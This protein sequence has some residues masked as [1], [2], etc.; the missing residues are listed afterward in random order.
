MER[1]GQYRRRQYRELR[2][3]RGGAVAVAV[4]ILS[5]VL[6]LGDGGGVAEKAA[7][8]GTDQ[9]GRARLGRGGDLRRALVAGSEYHG[10]RAG[11]G[12]AGSRART[13]RA[14]RGHHL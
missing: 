14:A 12:A 6:G 8:L 5:G 1:G 4:E 13:G 10:G 3:R 7:A 9:Q 11:A 2:Q